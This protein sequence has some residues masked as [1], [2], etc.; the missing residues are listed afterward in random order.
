MKM[1]K[2]KIGETF[3]LQGYMR[4]LNKEYQKRQKHN[5]NK[6]RKEEKWN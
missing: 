4:D 3:D 5:E 1:N 2:Y 6:Q